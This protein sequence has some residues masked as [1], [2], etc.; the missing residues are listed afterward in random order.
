M[1]LQHTLIRGLLLAGL[2]ATS[3]SWA[4]ADS[5]VLATIESLHVTAA[6]LQQAIDSSPYA[7]QFVAMDQDDQAALR[8]D[9]M[10][11]LVVNRLL[12]LEAE[13]LG[14]DK[15]PTFAKELEDFRLGLL[16]RHYMDQLR[17]RLEL[18]DQTKASVKQ[19]L[20][21]DPDAQH[22]AGAAM[23]A[24]RY[25]GLRMLTLQ[26]LRERYQVQVFEDRI[27]TAQADTLLLRGDGLEIRYAEVIDGAEVASPNPEWVKDQL[28]RRAELLLIAKAADAE[29]V[30]VSAKLDSYRRERLP[31]LLLRQ[32]ETEWVPNEQVLR[33]WFAAHP[34]IGQIPERRHVGQ[35]VLPTHRM[36]EEIL[37]RIQ[38]GESLFTLAEQFSVDPYGRDRR[39]DMGWVRAGQG[40]PQIEQAIAKL[41]NGEVSAIVETPLGF[42]L[43]MIIERREGSKKVYGGVRDKIFQQVVAQRMQPWLSELEQRYQVVWNV[44][45][46]PAQTP[47][48]D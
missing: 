32:K 26:G 45:Q 12:L 22:A 13:R 15:Q 30:D 2:I 43:V 41:A 18:D 34:D 3:T 11:R 17:A 42:H 25:R 1:P 8:G 24:D 29:G 35:I 4:K 37:T 28:Y 9:M 14:L 40:L 39:G 33:D 38:A 44:L 7:T 6:D 10:R 20:P 48:R 36:A 46:S 23:L 47:T 19:Q 27:P 31:A 21:G 5:E 16:Y